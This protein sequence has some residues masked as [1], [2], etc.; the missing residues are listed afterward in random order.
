MKFGWRGALVLLISAA[1][2]YYAFK[3]VDWSQ[4]IAQARNA[5]WLLLLLAAA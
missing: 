5:N 1:C 3:N 2:L 4:T